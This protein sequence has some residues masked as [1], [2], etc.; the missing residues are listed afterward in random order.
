MAK[1]YGTLKGC[2]GEATR[3]GSALSGIKVSAQ[4]CDG[5]IIVRMYQVEKDGEE[6]TYCKI[7]YA[8]GSSSIIEKT[9]FEG[10]IE[11]FEKKFVEVKKLASILSKKSGTN[12]IK[13]SKI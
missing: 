3:L 6:K 13:H 10:T 4:S 7:G 11:E 12:I 8:E 2:R 1:F 9:V 5:S